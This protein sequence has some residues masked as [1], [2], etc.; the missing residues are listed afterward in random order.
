LKILRFFGAFK[1]KAG[2]LSG[3]LPANRLNWIL[4]ADMADA[5]LSDDKRRFTY[6]D[7]KA[8]ELA[9]GERFEL[10]YGESCAMAAPNMYHQVILGVLTAKFYNFFEGKSCKV[11]PA[12]FDVRL[13]YEA[14]ESDDTVVQ[15]DLSVICDK[16]KRGPEGGRGAPDLA[17]EILSPSN[18]AGEM[19]RKFSL[20]R[21]AGVR[22]YWV[23]Y[24]EEKSLVVHSFS[25]GQISSRAYNS[26]DIVQVGIFPGLEIPLEPVFAE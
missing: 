3:I 13:F 15:P 1:V 10:I 2:A 19:S 17:V 6:A 7:Y 4:E 9:P 8:W 14:D 18:T 26:P 23:V 25:N 5:A 16:E 12:P 11:C 20:Y 21:D 22:E 24:P